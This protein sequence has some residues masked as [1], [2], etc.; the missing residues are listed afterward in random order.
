[1]LAGGEI[2]LITATR[3]EEKPSLLRRSSYPSRRLKAKAV[4]REPQTRDS[5]VNQVVVIVAP[6]ECISILGTVLQPLEMDLPAALLILVHGRTERDRPLAS[7]LNKGRFPVEEGRVGSQLRNGHALIVQ[8]DEFLGIGRLDRLKTSL[9]VTGDKNQSIL[10]RSAVSRY[11]NDTIVVV[12]TSLEPA[13]SEAIRNMRSRGERSIALDDSDR[14]WL[15]EHAP[16][17]VP[18]PADRCLVAEAIGSEIAAM[19][20]A[21]AS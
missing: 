13:E 18:D 10:L 4:P 5:E 21:R 8:A 1:M 16:K 6:A 17:V 20:G 11:G 19:V 12:L 2:P 7:N 15:N 3:T 14:G 9:P